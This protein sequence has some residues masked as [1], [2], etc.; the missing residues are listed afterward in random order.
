MTIGQTAL[1]KSNGVRQYFGIWEPP[2]PVPGQEPESLT[3]VMGNL[4]NK[5]RGVE[6][7][8]KKRM[9]NHNEALEAKKK[10]AQVMRS[11]R[12]TGIT[13]TQNR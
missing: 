6:T 13:G 9:A 12:A 7:D 3:D 5:V 1:L 11:R 4:A 8:D 2:K 10:A